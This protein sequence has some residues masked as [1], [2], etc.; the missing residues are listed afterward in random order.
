MTTTTPDLRYP[1]RTDRSTR[2]SWRANPDYLGPE[3]RGIYDA[4]SE[5]PGWQDRGDS[6]KLYEMGYFAGDVILEIGVYGGRSAVVEL[7]GVLSNPARARKPQF[8]GIDFDP[9]A[10][11]RSH[12]TL[13]VAGLDHLALLYEGDLQRFV[14]DFCIRPTMVFVDGDH[15]YPG[16]R[17]MGL[18]GL[19][20]RFL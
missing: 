17:K 16:A 20:K 6:Y 3:H 1:D 14:E 4:T 11:V 5:L 2:P 7:R 19:L 9:A 13:E 18:Y 12:A 8:F 15:A 10:I